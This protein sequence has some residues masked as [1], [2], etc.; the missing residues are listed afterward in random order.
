MKWVCETST[1]SEKSQ[2]GACKIVTLQKFSVESG[3]SMHT[4]QENALFSGKNYTIIHDQ[5]SRQIY[6]NDKLTD[7]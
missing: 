4:I 5:R 2:I 1:V 6:E 7:D 3:T